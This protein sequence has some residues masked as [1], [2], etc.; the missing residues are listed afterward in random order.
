MSSFRILLVAVVVLG[1]AVGA[2][3][4]AF[5]LEFVRDLPSFE[6]LADYRPSL[7]STVFDRQGRPI[8][9]FYEHRRQLTPL[10]DVPDLVIQAFLAAEDDTFY[11]HGGVDYRSILRAGGDTVQGASTITQQTVKQ[12]L[13]SSEQTYTRK[14]RELILARRIEQRFSK[15]EILYLYLNQIYF[16]AGAYGV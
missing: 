11:E 1:L 6:T 5:Y 8:G 2:A 10:E 16:G 3:A 12:L 15:D 14:I 9:E 13:L 7:T 4:T